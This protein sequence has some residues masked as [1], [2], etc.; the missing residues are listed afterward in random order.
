MS[1]DKQIERV[2]NAL[3]IADIINDVLNLG[4]TD[5]DID[6]IKALPASTKIIGLIFVISNAHIK[7]GRN[8]NKAQ[9]LEF[10][11]NGFDFYSDLLKSQ[12]NDDEQS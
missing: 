12:E 3:Y 4:K 11:G 7:I 6:K 9:L 5:L 2:H 8:P 1:E 10:V